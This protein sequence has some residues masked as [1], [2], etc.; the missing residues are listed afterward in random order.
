[1][2]PSSDVFA[3]D[4]Q[5]LLRPASSELRFLPEGPYPVKEGVISWVA[6]Q[7]GAEANFGSL[8]LLDLQS[9]NNQSHL[10]KGRPGFAF[11]TTRPGVFAIGMEREVG[12]YDSASGQWELLADGIDR[13]VTGTVI[14]D[15]VVCKQGIIF[16]C[17]DLKFAEAKAGLYFF[18]TRDRKLF[19]LRSDQTCSNGKIVLNDDSQ[20]RFVD[21]DTPTKQVREYL[22]DEEQGKIVSEKVVLDL[23]SEASFPD[24][25]TATPDMQGVIIS[26][27]NPQHAEVGETRCYDLAT[28]LLKGVWR[29]P[30]SP[31][32]TCPQLVRVGQKVKIVITTAVEHMSAERQ[33]TSPQ[34]G[35][36]FIGETPYDSVP[37]TPPVQL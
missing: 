6:I 11:P 1:M 3:I 17:K 16:G 4:C 33:K 30:G 9:G 7:H 26:M 8:N 25:M 27:Y 15:G 35:F 36:I 37:S 32:A 31:Q 34:A 13:S 21:I 18:R 19:K 29:T 12:L 10:L 28:G 5:V 20:I 2:N 24:G 14:N 22:I 23:N